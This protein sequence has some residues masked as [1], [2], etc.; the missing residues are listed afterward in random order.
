M[1]KIILFI[2]SL[3]YFGCLH[4]QLKLADILFNNFE[5]KTAA[6][7]YSESSSLSK[8]QLENYALSYFYTNDFH[9]SNTVFKKVLEDKP[10]DFFLNY[11]YSVCLKSIG[12]YKSAK[13]ILNDLHFQDSLNNRIVFDLE[14]I[15]SLIKW[16]TLKI[17]KKLASFEKINSVSSEFSPSFF[18]DGIYYI[19]ERGNKKASIN[20][21]NLISKNDSLTFKE[22]KEFKEELI[23][24][25]SYGSAMSPRTSVNKI[26]LN[27]PLL[28]KNL[29]NPIPYSSIIKNEQ[30]ISHNNFN[31]TS[32]N[33]DNSNSKIFYTRH[34]Y[35]TKLNASESINPLIYQG[36]IKPEK[37]KIILRRHVSVRFLSSFTGSGEAC[38]SSDGKTI[39][40]VSDNKKGY[41]QTDIYMSHKSKF[42]KWGKAINL[43]PL[44][45]SPYKEESP[46]I[47]DDSILYFSS[48]GFAG[49]GKADIF[50][51]KIT[52]DSVYN[53]K[54]L[55]YP[56]NS[57]GDDIHFILHPFDESI[58]ILNSNRAKGKGEEDIYFAHMIPISPYVKGYVRLN[59]DSSLQNNTIVRLLDENNEELQQFHT[60][61][62]GKYRFSLKENRIYKV[63]A[64]KKNLYRDT[65]V[66]SDTTLFRHERRDIILKEDKTIQG[67]TVKR[68]NNEI[69]PNVKID[70]NTGI[71]SKKL[72]IYSDENG[73]YQFAFNTDS[74]LLLEVLNDS[75]W[76]LKEFFI[77]SNYLFKK[78]YN[79]ELDPLFK[80]FKVKVLDQETKE[81]QADAIVYLIN[82]DGNK[83]DSSLTDS[84]GHVYFNLKTANDYEMHAYKGK[85]DG[86]ANLHTSLLVRNNKDINVF[87][88]TDYV[89][90]LGKIIDTDTKEPLDFVKITIVDSTTNA[91]DLHLTNELGNFELHIHAN[92]IYYLIVEKR[93]YFTKTLVLNIGDSIPEIIDLNKEYN[94]SLKR[95]G[96]IIEPIYFDF[97]SHKITKESRLELDQLAEF[98]K[99]NKKESIKIFGYTDCQGTKEYLLKNLNKVLGQKRAISVRKYLQSKNIPSSRVTV[100]GR[101]AVNFLN[102][103]FTAGSCTDFEHRENR[104]C[105]FQLN[106][107]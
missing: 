51:C 94:L 30:I 41:G 95:S 87:I 105:E 101:G 61:I 35:L 73:Y 46:R 72:S 26:D 7:I 92:N 24:I 48:N 81:I 5:Y 21:I 62:S 57:A 49:Y 13:K 17:L 77:D 14:N 69:I 2:L 25:L 3:F 15:D 12:E 70:I 64:T 56:I 33:V 22:K 1:R 63:A 10:N 23:K 53:V 4:G 9:K 93:N 18:D 78:Q 42:G 55:P 103:C 37:K 27:I 68:S 29:D 40:F 65:I 59:S 71:R 11:C 39:Y 104:R 74:I 97:K 102:S 96:F 106:D 52:N 79:L 44:V 31:V 84:T 60:G 90:T 86:I 88:T 85:A 100:I 67:Y 66:I 58:A 32:F 75:L 107:L 20:N 19:T 16:D 43:G 89:P 28:F 8:K 45:N 6:K 83:I 47:Y 38:V 98:L 34:P 36:K 99:N 80:E 91:K 76:G 50:K 82:M 54:H